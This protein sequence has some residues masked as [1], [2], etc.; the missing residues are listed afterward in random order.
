MARGKGGNAYYDDDDFDDGYDDYDADDYAEE[1]EEEAAPPKVLR[2]LSPAAS[3]VY[4]V[5]LPSL[6]KSSSA[7]R[8][9]EGL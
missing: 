7:R 3:A 9:K 5:N 6:P 2:R 4:A 1:Y 8:R